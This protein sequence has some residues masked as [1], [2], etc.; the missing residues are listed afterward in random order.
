M[1]Q[2]SEVKNFISGVI[3]YERNDYTK[4]DV[5]I[6]PHT[7]DGEASV[8]YGQINV[9]IHVPDKVIAKGK[10]K[11]VYMIDALLLLLPLLRVNFLSGNYCYLML[12]RTADPLEFR[13]KL[14]LTAGRNPKLL[15]SVCDRRHLN[16][17]Q[18]VDSLLHLCRTVGTAKILQ[19][20]YL[21]LDVRP[22]VVKF[23]TCMPHCLM[24]V[25]F[26]LPMLVMVVILR[27]LR[28]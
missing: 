7:I 19:N 11:A 25:M 4:E 10:G 9:N 16:L 3:D 6:V 8:R 5:I 14:F 1:L 23:M 20:I 2:A 15:C 17:R 13:Q 28:R 24:V 18:L 12:N 22:Y 27:G 21:L 26:M